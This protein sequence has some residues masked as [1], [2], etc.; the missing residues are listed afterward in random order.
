V[1]SVILI[2]HSGKEPGTEIARRRHGISRLPQ[3]EGEKQLKEAQSSPDRILHIDIAE[4]RTEEKASTLGGSRQKPQS[5]LSPGCS[6]TPIREPFAAFLDKLVTY[7][8]HAA[9]TDSGIPFADLPKQAGTTTMQRGHPFAPVS[10]TASHIDRPNHPQANGQVERMS[11]TP[12][13][14]N[15]QV[16]PLRQP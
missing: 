6:I 12:K 7:A 8:S 2:P 10:I 5:S 16:P 13:A 1:A 9:L 4:A 11:R 14:G 15:G 3:I